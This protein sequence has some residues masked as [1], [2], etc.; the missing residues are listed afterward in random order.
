MAH[1]ATKV[2]MGTT[3]ASFKVVDNYDADPATFIAGLCVHLTSAG[4]LTLA[5]A[6]GSKLGISLGA[7]QS[8]T[9]RT[10]VVRAGLDVPIQLT[11]AFSP[12]IGAQVHIS[13]TTGK[14]IASGAGAT[15]VNAIYKTGALT[16]IAEDGTETASVVAL[17]DFQGGL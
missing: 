1:S 4:A 13:D 7:S 12:V 6:S 10:A 8:N 17:I 2:L 11:A 3:K 14:A 5:S 16:M 9:K 15:G